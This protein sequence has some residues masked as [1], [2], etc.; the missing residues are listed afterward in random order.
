LSQ[1]YADSV[2][3]LQG[4]GQGGE[5]DRTMMT[6]GALRPEDGGSSDEGQEDV[7]KLTAELATV[8]ESLVKREQENDSLKSRIRKL[9]IA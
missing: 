5:T 8:E 1:L 3:Q 7:R 6:T 2:K 4:V 9:A